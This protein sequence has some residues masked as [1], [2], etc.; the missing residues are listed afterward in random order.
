MTERERA[1]ID[2]ILKH[3]VGLFGGSIRNSLGAIYSS[4]AAKGRL[5]S[6]AT[7]K[8]AVR[9]MVTSIQMMLDS[10]EPR[11]R[12]I[13]ADKEAFALLSNAMNEILDVCACELPKVVDMA[14]GR[15][16]LA[17]DG[18]VQKAAEGLYDAMRAD[19]VAKLEILAYDYEQVSKTDADPADLPRPQS[20]RG[21]RPP[22]DFWDDMWASIAASLYEGNLIPK[23]Q[24]DIERAM[25][26]WIEARGHSAAVST[27]R[28]RARRLWDRI[29]QQDD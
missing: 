24:A 7:I 13:S 26:A 14:R 9:E 25:T 11:V 19:F 16:V 29:A 15:R 8:V 6:G 4:H 5:Q 23:S 20:K 12:A 28:A 21:G 3:A 1:Q 2:R 17:D 27:V 10:L 18:S 22:A